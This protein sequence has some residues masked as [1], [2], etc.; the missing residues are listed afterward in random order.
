MHIPGKVKVDVFHWQHLGI[1]TTGCTT[2][3]PHYWAKRRFA[4]S[5]HSFL[6]NLVQ[7]VCQTNGNG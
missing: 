3:D 5:N 2:L 6:A 4:N 7:G 1:T